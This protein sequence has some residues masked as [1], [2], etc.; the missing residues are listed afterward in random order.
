MGISTQLQYA[1]LDDLYLDAKNPRLGRHQASTTLSQEEVLDMMSDWVLDELAVSY[2]ESGFWPHE[3]LLV[4]K[5]EVD[6]KQRIV[7][8]EG[9]RRLAA[10]IY[11]RRAVNG[12]KV[13]QKWSSLVES[14]DESDISELFNQ[15]PYIQVDS[16][17]KIESFLGFRH[18]TGIKEWKPEEK[19]RYIAHLIDDRHM[20]YEQVMR[21]IGSKTR[22]VRENYISYRLLLQMESELEDFSH[23]YAE[24]RFSV[25]NLTLK[26]GGVQKYLK[27]DILAAPETA[28]N[29]VPVNHLKNLGNFA[30]WLFGNDDKPPLF[31]DSRQKDDFSTILES[32]DAV[33][34]LENDKRPKF[35]YAFQLACG[36]E[37]E[38]IRL[39]NE[40]CDNI[41]ISLSRVHR[42][43]DSLELHNAIER[44][45]V[46]F[47]ALLDRFPDVRAEFQKDN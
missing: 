27:I 43:T 1:T 42:Y 26:T 29:P 38:I 47:K 18:V 11:L 16:R 3:A 20:T 37:L 25:M 19:A 21:K 4:V 39:I 33:R 15:I 28:Q 6:G 31:I 24:D 2:L 10:L 9:N 13:S 35:D 44:L 46:D 23:K 41:Q 40:A 22:T 36:D 7:V 5:E 14:R 32:P 8:V 30:L 12:E 45:S 17:E 34:Y